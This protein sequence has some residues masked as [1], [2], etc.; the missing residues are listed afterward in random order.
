MSL[1]SFVRGVK[2]RPIF[3]PLAAIAT[4]LSPAGLS[5]EALYVLDTVDVYGAGET[6]QVQMLSRTD[7][8]QSTPGTSPVKEVSK[9]AGVSFQAAD[10]YGAYEWAVRISVRGFS[11]TQLG[12][13]LDDVPLGEMFYSSLNGLYIS[14]AIIDENLGRTLLSQ[15]TAALDTASTSSLGGAIQ[16]YSDDPNDQKGADVAQTIGSNATR[17]SFVRLDSGKLQNEG[18]LY[19]AAV[20]QSQELWKGNGVQA[21]DQLNV[22]YVQPV[23]DSKLSF[24]FDYSDRQEMDY[25]DMTKEWIGKLGYGWSNYWPDLSAAISNASSTDVCCGVPVGGGQ[26]VTDPLDAAYFSASGVRRDFFGN[27]AFDATLTSSLFWKNTFYRHAYQGASTWGTPY[28]ATPGANGSPLSERVLAYDTDRS[29]LL[30]ALDWTLGAHHINTGI[31]Y[32]VNSATQ[33]RYFFPIYLDGPLWSPYQMPNPATAFLTQWVYRF[34]TDTVQYHVQDTWEISDRL[35]LHGGFKSLYSNTTGT[36]TINNIGNPLAQGSLASSGDFLPQLGANWKV[37]PEDEIFVDISKTIRSFQ[38]GGYGLGL[39][40][41]AVKNQSAFQVVQQ[42]IR[43]ETAWTYEAGYRFDRTFGGDVLRGFEGLLTVYHVDYSDRLLNI[44]PGG[45]LI[46]ATGGAAILANVGGV[47]TDG[48]EVSQTLHL[49]ERLDWYNALSHNLSI[50]DSNY[51][52]GNAIIATAGKTVVDTPRLLYKSD[53][54]YRAEDYF[55][56]LNADYMSSRYFS[57]T[58]DQFVDPRWIFNFGAGKSLGKRLGASDISLQLNI[59]NLFDE[60]YISTMG[61]GGFTASGD[62]QTL[63]VGAPRQL[64]ITLKGSL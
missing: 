8:Q 14:R 35:A 11:Q 60:R 36:P 55:L 58:N 56:R 16:F 54:I 1:W 57:Y 6:R 63:Q 59:L 9:L 49:F 30:S 33:G 44:A 23:G 61:T 50:Y 27:V 28:K 13:T 2:S 7:T 12:F 51:S 5:A 15:S 62:Y 25:Q 39:S 3:R 18:K 4:L 26:S 38:V 31:W 43:P 47:T 45:S 42:R 10:A 21:Y 64:F 34:N 32:E 24:Y 20:R 37:S 46:A 41:W 48:M 40:P 22:K 53:L 29:G 19:L 17:R 52:D